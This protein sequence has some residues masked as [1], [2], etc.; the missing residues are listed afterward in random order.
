VCVDG[1]GAGASWE[2]EDEGAGGGRCEGVDAV[3]IFR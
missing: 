2:A 3:W 1:D